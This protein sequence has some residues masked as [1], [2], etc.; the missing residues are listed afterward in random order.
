MKVLQPFSIEITHKYKDI[1]KLF[2]PIYYY[3]THLSKKELP[4]PTP[5]YKPI[6]SHKIPQILL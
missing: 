4:I 6:E 3:P 5:N 2:P 1:P